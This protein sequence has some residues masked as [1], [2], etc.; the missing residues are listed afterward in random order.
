ML[1]PLAAAPLLGNM[2]FIRQEPGRGRGEVRPGEVTAV[3]T[4]GSGGSQGRRELSQGGAENNLV[5]ARI[6]N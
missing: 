1:P 6:N 4:E 5:N 2:T 3:S